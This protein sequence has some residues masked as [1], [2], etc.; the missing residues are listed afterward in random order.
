MIRRP[1]RSTRTDTPFPYTTLFRSEADRGAEGAEADQE[2]GR[3]DGELQH[4][5]DEDCVFH[6]VLRLNRLAV[7]WEERKRWCGLVALGRHA[8]VDDRQHHE[9]EGLQCDDQDVERGPREARSEEHTS[10]L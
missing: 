7:G 3:D 2:A 1:P 6:G 9:D 10:E 8:E 4:F 5:G